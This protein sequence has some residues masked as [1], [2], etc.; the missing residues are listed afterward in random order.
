MKV[1]CKTNEAFE[2]ALTTSNTYNLIRMKNTSVLIIND[3]GEAR[4]YGAG[5]FLLFPQLEESNPEDLVQ[6]C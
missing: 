4:W 6:S 2:D 3:L 1:V 5:R